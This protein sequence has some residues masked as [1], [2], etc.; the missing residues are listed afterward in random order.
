MRSVITSY[1]IHY[2]K[3]YD[4]VRDSGIGIPPELRAHVGEPFV[5]GHALE[6]HFS[7]PIAFGSSG[8]GLGPTVVEAVMAAHGGRM[9]LASVD[10][11][12]T[13]VRL[14]FPAAGGESGGL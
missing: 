2:T 9:E 4:V 7:D 11:H 10:G 13:M 6:R 3:L 5:T 14:D 12:G 1:S 8:L